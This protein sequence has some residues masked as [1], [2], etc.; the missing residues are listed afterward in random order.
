M[1]AWGIP[2][3]KLSFAIIFIWFGVLKPLGLSAAIPIVKATVSWLPVFE[4]KIWVNIIGWWE[5]LIG[6]LFLFKGTI[7]IAIF[8]LFLQMSGTFMPMI[9]LPEVVYQDGNLLLPTM[10]G[11]YIIKNIMIIS[12]ALVVGGTFYAKNKRVKK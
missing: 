12:A 1:D 7:R 10:E 3:I 6:V 9:F 8:L 4:P 2:F 11:Q 5:V